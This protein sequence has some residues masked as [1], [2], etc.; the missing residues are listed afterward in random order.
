MLLVLFDSLVEVLES[1]INEAK[2][3]AQDS[4]VVEQVRIRVI[5][6]DGFVKMLESVFDVLVL[7]VGLMFVHE[8]H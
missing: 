6:G 7:V 8:L 2:I 4:S 5:Q 3:E 1:L